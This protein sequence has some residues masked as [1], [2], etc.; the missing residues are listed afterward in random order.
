MPGKLRLAFIFICGVILLTSPAGKAEEIEN[1]DCLMCHADPEL[2]PFIDGVKFEASIHAGFLCTSCH[3]DITEVPHDAPL[4]PVSC[5]DCHQIEQEIYL[6]S[7]HIQMANR[8]QEASSTCRSCHGDPHALLD[9]RNP[10][11]PVFRKNIPATC[12]RC[13]QSPEIV[14][15]MDA[16]VSSYLESV[17]G[18]AQAD[19]RTEAAVCTDCHG[20]HDINREN[21]PESKLYWQNIPGTCGRCHENVYKTYMVSIHGQGILRGERDVPICTDCHG[22]HEIDATS[23]EA[24]KVFP[25]HIVETC[26]Q[27]HAAERITTKYS[28]PKYV[29][30]TYRDSYHGLSNRMGS[31]K[32]ANCA[33][34]HGFHNILPHTD[35]R[36]TIHPDNLAKTCGKC[37]AGVG[38]LVTIGKIH[39]GRSPGVENRVSGWVRKFYIW[40][41][42]VVIGFMFLH[43]SLDFCVK[44]K[45]HYA[46]I[47]K[48]QLRERMNVNERIQHFILFVAFVA[49]AYSG[50]A[51]KYPNAWWVFVFSGHVEWRSWM[52]RAGAAVFCTLAVYHLWYLFFTRKGRW[53]LTE[54]TPRKHDLFQMGQMFRYY[55]GRRK[56][57]PVFKHYSYIEKMEYWALVWGGVI[58]G[59]TGLL[60]LNQATFLRFAPKWLFDV[61]TTIHYYE[62]VLACLAILLWHG[63][64]VMYDPDEYPMK[65]T[66][67]SGHETHHD[68]ERRPHQDSDSTE[69]DAPG[70]DA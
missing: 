28:L 8:E 35:P 51:L 61:V 36:S 69:S 41:I 13:H 43:N 42:V 70:E 5:A 50:F 44:I 57:K 20:A 64:F 18:L 31:M 38:D 11:S 56:D 1:A 65:W 55:F 7:D 52:H 58:M 40:L 19:G 21:N 15:T 54:L 68:K 47:R 59:G 27:C 25:S 53:Q 12:A 16:R 48:H 49:L 3:S 46:Q 62:A 6:N 4:K 17:H 37:H 23:M 10:D 22:E 30:Q 39:S 14:H 63:Y 66:W 34:C 33:S 24:S 26:S 32:A 45:R 29:V 2:A 9:S 67:L 60:M